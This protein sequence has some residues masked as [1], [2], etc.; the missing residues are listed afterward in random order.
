MWF[1]TISSKNDGF[2]ANSLWQLF[3]PMP[4]LFECTLQWPKMQAN[5]HSMQK[6]TPQAFFFIFVFF[7]FASRKNSCWI[8]TVAPSVGLPIMAIASEMKE[9]NLSQLRDL[10][11]RTLHEA[12]LFLWRKVKCNVDFC[13][14]KYYWWWCCCLYLKMFQNTLV[15]CVRKVK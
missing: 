13:H 12:L 14:V 10:R 3:M 9:M 8:W 6:Q 15:W 1:I 5:Q 7:V 2:G 4:D 11:P